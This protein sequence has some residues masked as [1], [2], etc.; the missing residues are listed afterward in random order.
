MEDL[1]LVLRRG[2]EAWLLL[3]LSGGDV[4]AADWSTLDDALRVEAAVAEVRGRGSGRVGGDGLGS[5]GRGPALNSCWL[6]D[7]LALDT[8][9][10][11]GAKRGW[12]L[13]GALPA[14]VTGCGRGRDGDGV[15]P[16]LCN[17]ELDDDRVMELD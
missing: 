11:E 8:M 13:V 5:L 3:G 16:R 14:T 4:D 1:L 15:R 6:D 17:W 12:R 7:E 9:G 10:A 2:C